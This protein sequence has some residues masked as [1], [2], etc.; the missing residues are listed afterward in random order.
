MGDLDNFIFHFLQNLRTPGADQVM[1]FVSLFGKQVLL[2]I[3][4]SVGSLWLFWNG[5]RKAAIHWLAAYVST[6]IMTYALKFSTRVERPVDIHNGFSFPSAHVSTSLAV[7][8]FL[9]LLVAR[10]LPFKRRW[11]PY[12]LAGILVVA[13]AFSRLYL[14]VHWFSDVLGGASVGL[15][16]ITLLGIAYDRHPAPA[17]RLKPLLAV[18]LAVLFMAGAWQL[19]FRYKQDLAD[20]APRTEMRIVTLSDWLNGYWRELPAYRIDIEGVNTQPLNFQWAGTLTTLQEILGKRGWH[21]APAFG[22]LRAMNWL[23]PHPESASLPILYQVHDGQQQKLLLV[24]KGDD[25]ERMTV[26][27]IWPANVETASRATKVWTGTVSYLA[28]DHSLPLISYLRTAP[29][30]DA[31]LAVLHKALEKSASV[32]TV[33]RDVRAPAGMQ[34]HGEVLLGWESNM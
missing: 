12:T 31:P 14:G 7:F 28:V 24:R 21:P 10:E 15:L 33:N 27:R 25:T 11:L 16:W 4:L 18:A 23:A 20:Y 3:V 8:G 9:A 2:A 32:R 19:E 6:V 30:F 34:W 1:T 13:I 29:E 26:L 22:V 17:L 5:Y